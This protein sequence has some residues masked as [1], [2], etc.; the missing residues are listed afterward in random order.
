MTGLGALPPPRKPQTL[1]Y[2]NGGSQPLPLFPPLAVTHPGEWHW[3]TWSV[4]QVLS[5]TVSPTLPAPSSHRDRSI[6]LFVCFFN[7]ST[8]KPRTLRLPRPQLEYASTPNPSTAILASCSKSAECDFIDWRRWACRFSTQ[9]RHAFSCLFLKQVVKWIVHIKGQHKTLATASFAEST[10]FI[11]QSDESREAAFSLSGYKT[12]DLRPKCLQA[13]G[14]WGQT[15]EVMRFPEKQRQRM[16]PCCHSSR[17]ATWAPPN[18]GTVPR[19]LDSATRGIDS[20]C[21]V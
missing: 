5:R 17:T 10:D 4:P 20:P 19:S 15:R 8:S 11:N 6:C 7:K 13:A 16:E 18:F 12:L 3:Q 21:A 14:R 1:Q 2:V 9:E